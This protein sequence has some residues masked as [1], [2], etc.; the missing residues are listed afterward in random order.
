[1][2]PLLLTIGQTAEMLGIGR[3]MV[4]DLMSSGELESCK[5][6][7]KCRR[8]PYESAVDYVRRMR[9]NGGNGSSPQ[10]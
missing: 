6:A 3:T 10:L 1:M 8:I 4:Y 5:L 7:K 2:P 9:E